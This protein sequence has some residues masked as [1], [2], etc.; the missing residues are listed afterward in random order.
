MR[1]QISTTGDPKPI[2]KADPVMPTMT[3][4]QLLAREARK[5]IFQMLQD[6]TGRTLLCYVSR[7]SISEEDIRYLQELLHA[8]EP[9]APLDLLLNSPGGSIRTADKLVRI[10]WSASSEYENSPPGEYRLIVPDQAKSAATLVALGASEI[11]MST[12]SELGPIDPQVELQDQD[13]NWNL[14]SAFDYIEAYEAAEDNYRKKPD[15]A[16][17]RAVFEKLDSVRFRSM[18]KMVEYT[19]MCAENVLKRHGG[20]YTLAPSLLMNRKRFPIHEQVIDWETAR[21]DLQLR[22]KFLGHKD[23]LWR[24]YWRLYGHL[25]HAVEDYRK[26]FE[27]AEVSLLVA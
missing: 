25:Q 18:E 9:E 1:T 5:A 17:Y 24:R 19:R 13:G 21:N 2:A 12:T 14:H 22:V 4:S 8:V 23:R 11:V 20:S 16:A 15:D 6:C 27:S 7:Y 26:I 10:L 3:E